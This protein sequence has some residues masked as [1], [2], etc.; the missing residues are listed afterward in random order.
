MTALPSGSRRARLLAAALDGEPGTGVAGSLALHEGPTDLVALAGQVQVL[1]VEPP[2]QF[3]GTLRELVMAAA[4][5]REAHL[6]ARAGDLA[7][8]GGG[9]S[10]HGRHEEPP[11]AARR[12]PRGRGRRALATSVASVLVTSG[13]AVGISAAS[14]QALPGDLLYPVKRGIEQVDL[15]LQRS[16]EAKGLVLLE[17]AA[18]R[19]TE[20]EGLLAAEGAASPEAEDLAAAVL[21]DFT[22]A[23]DAARA[24]LADAHGSVTGSSGDGLDEATGSQLGAFLAES[25]DILDGLS[26]ELPPD[27]TEAYPEAAE[28]VLGLQDRATDYCGDCAPPVPDALVDVASPTGQPS[29]PV[30]PLAGG[31]GSLSLPGSGTGVGGT[32]SLSPGG[33]SGG[34]TGAGPTPDS[35]PG[36]PSDNTGQQPAPG[37]APAGPEQPAPEEPA[38]GDVGAEPVDHSDGAGSGESGGEPVTSDPDSGTGAGT[39]DGT[40]TGGDT[41]TDSGGTG[42]G[43]TDTGGDTTTDTGGTDTGGTDTGGDTGTDG[44]TDTGGTDTGGDTGASTGGDTGTD[45]GTGGTSEPVAAPVDDSGGAAGPVADREDTG[46]VGPVPAEEPVSATP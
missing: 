11:P 37:N 35:E 2:A 39:G 21:I 4:V 40:A 29:S 33:E 44:G 28:A 20:L 16:T 30:A 12:R 14:A 32:D 24:A 6:A 38:T 9:P 22:E 1:A 7:Q 26:G 19:L 18:T 42:T 3:L 8:A 34:S 15:A 5:E 31:D 23:T 41:S 43:G 25:T 45:G 10:A 17:H 46:E 13:T 36:P 27:A